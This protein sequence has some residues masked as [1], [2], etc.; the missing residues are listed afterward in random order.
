MKAKAGNRKN[1]LVP[2][3]RFRGFDTNWKNIKLGDVGSTNGGLTYSPNDLVDDES[4]GTLVL[5]SSNIQNGI[6]SFHDNVY[7]SCS[8]SEKDLV[9][10]NDI[11]ICVR[12]GSKN[13][14]GKSLIIKKE[15]VGYAFGAFMAI[16]RSDY[17][18]FIYHFFKSDKFFKQVHE[19]LGATINQITGKSLNS[20]KLYIPT[21]PEQQK[22]ASFLSA[23]DEKIQQLTRKKE[24]L[25]QYKKGVMQQLFSGKLRFKDSNGRAFP[26]WEEKRLGEVCD[27]K[28]GFTFKSTTYDE[29][30]EFNV[31]TIKNV[32]NGQ[33]LGPFTKIKALP[34][35]IE[36][37]QK[38]QLGDILI[39]MTGNVGRVC[40]VTYDNCLLNQRVGKLVPI[41][42]N[43]DYLYQLLSDYKFLDAMVN[44]G[45][46][47]AQLN[48]GKKDILDYRIKIAHS[49]VEQNKIATYLANIDA[50]IKQVDSQITNTQTFKKG[51]LQQM[52]V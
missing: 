16:Y 11:L 28:N 31:V 22:I 5:R 4:K 14:I 51:L 8:I 20:F 26:K 33:M 27:L 6:M 18:L 35:K 42:I 15:H 10:E 49:S 29:N 37:H 48:I 12:N 40:Y 46:G 19:H 45:Q 25:E 13:L 41:D 3:L 44:V 30:G 9:K 24:L 43:P 34:N 36:K 50:K 23:V 21:L 2:K 39:S 17:N 47:A 52:F 32:Q 38:L 1:G 7:V